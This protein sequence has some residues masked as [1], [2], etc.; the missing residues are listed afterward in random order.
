MVLVSNYMDEDVT[1]FLMEHRGLKMNVDTLNERKSKVNDNEEGDDNKNEQ[2]II[3][4]KNGK[5]NK[6]RKRKR[7]AITGKKGNSNKKRKM[8]INSPPMEARTDIVSYFDDAEVKDNVF[9]SKKFDEIEDKLEF[10]ESGG[11]LG[12]EKTRKRR[13]WVKLDK[14]KIF[15]VELNGKTIFYCPH[16]FVLGRPG[17]EL[18]FSVKNWPCRNEEEWKEGYTAYHCWK[19]RL[20]HIELFMEKRT[21]DG[22]GPFEDATKRSRK[23]NDATLKAKG[24]KIADFNWDYMEEKATKI[25]YKDKYEC[26]VIDQ[27]WIDSDD[28]L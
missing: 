25:K 8:N 13:A 3:G 10:F 14:E 5:V 22:R 2:I 15:R 27:N 4:K 28:E 16:L 17:F 18:A 23:V 11:F 9:S 26:V 19:R 20:G 24:Y 1:N 6:G 21:R 7:K 12:K